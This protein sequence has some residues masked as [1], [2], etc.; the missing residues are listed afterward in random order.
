MQE[1]KKKKLEDLIKIQFL[2]FQIKIMFKI[3]K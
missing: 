3:Y 1:N 2:F